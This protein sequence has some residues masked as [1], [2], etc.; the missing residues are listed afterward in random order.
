MANDLRVLMVRQ[1]GVFTAK[2][3]YEHGVTKPEIE[4]M[5]QSGDLLS[6]RQGVWT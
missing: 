6:V 1:G 2:Q 3:A 5:L 4:S